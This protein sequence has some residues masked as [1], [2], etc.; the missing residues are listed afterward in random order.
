MKFS[1]RTYGCQMNERDSEAI[2][3]LL[4]QNGHE[5]TNVE[6]EAELVIVNTCT[7]REK[8]E[9]KALGKLR[10][11][12]A[13]K[14]R[15]PNFIVGAVGCVVQRLE[16]E[17]LKFVPK[18]DFAVGT[19]SKAFLPEIIEVIKSGGGPI[20][21]CANEVEFN[22]KAWGEHKE[23]EI[24]AYVNIIL[25]CERR[26]AYCIVPSVRGV[27]WS[28]EP[29]KIVEE[30]QRVVRLGAKEV[31]LLGQSVLQYG[32]RNN[33]W[34]EDYVSPRGY[35]E[36][37]PRLMEVTDTVPGIERLRF[38]SSHPSR[39]TDEFA[40]AMSELPSVCEHMHLPL[41]SGSDEVLKRMRRGYDTQRYR[42]AL[43]SM[44]KYMS[45]F[46]IT[47]DVIVG[48]P[49]ETE[50][51]FQETRR[52]MEEMKFDNAY[53]FKYS[54]RPGT[55]AA[56]WE[57]DVSED[58]KIRRHQILLDD[59]NERGQRINE[60]LVGTSVEVLVEGVSKRNDDKWSG[61]TRTNKIVVFDAIGNL[62]IGDLV[63]VKISSAMPQTIYGE[64][65]KC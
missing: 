33:V 42:E 20:V 43:A 19:R 21:D 65:E 41:Q 32:V 51:Q 50:E 62:E 61:R 6:S 13:R 12:C 44:K 28:R 7:I 10:N 45:G 1:I 35:L 56:E 37:F 36:P 14:R 31:T 53:I 63:I 5:Q 27:E 18:L 17:I 40:R 39:C 25:G 58:E 24:T 60:H 52:F 11:L 9:S 64:I 23:G 38:I 48:F 46:A 15:E 26:C 16:N 34:S 29:S 4:V 54:T 49:G 57:D 3:A 55:P 22:E 2:A 8:A 47:T 59:Q 30:V